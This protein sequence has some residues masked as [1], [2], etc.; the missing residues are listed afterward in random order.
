[1]F[2]THRSRWRCGKRQ[3]LLVKMTGSAFK[4]KILGG[5]HDGEHVFVPQTTIS[6]TGVM[7]RQPRKLG[8]SRDTIMYIAHSSTPRKESLHCS[9][10]RSL[11]N[12]IV[13]SE[14]MLV[15]TLCEARGKTLTIWRGSYH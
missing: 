7:L 13:S 10:I 4:A 2:D 3:P 1:V 9:K 14:S 12:D 8:S 11:V 15:A 5:N 6:A